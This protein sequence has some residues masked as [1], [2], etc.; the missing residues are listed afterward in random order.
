MSRISMIVVAVCGLLAGPALGYWE[1]DGTNAWPAGPGYD[2]DPYGTWAWWQTASGTV[3]GGPGYLD[4]WAS[5]AGGAEVHL[6]PD[7]GLSRFAMA[8]SGASA[9]S[10]Y[11][12]VEDQS[13]KDI[14]FT[15]DVTIDGAG[16]EYWG[17]ALDRTGTCDAS[18]FSGGYAM[19]GSDV[20]NGGSFFPYGDG[21]GEAFSQGGTYATND[22]K[23][24]DVDPGDN[25]TYYYQ[26][27]LQG[28]YEGSLSFTCEAHFYRDWYEPFGNEL[29]VLSSVMGHA[30]AQGQLVI[31][32]PQFYWGGFDAKVEYGLMG[33]SELRLYGNIDDLQ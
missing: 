6:T 33:S 15:I 13:S 2:Y 10:Y 20:A 7:L 11:R 32:D 24:V 23:C 17:S 30:F 27:F 4:A 8:A 14:C 18:S 31:N 29:T 3:S 19:L 9:S 26:G 1:Y 12:W 25:Y 22:W 28:Y 16:V 21:H 5:A